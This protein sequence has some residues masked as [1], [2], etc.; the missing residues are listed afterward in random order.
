MIELIQG[1]L[2][3]SIAMLTLIVSVLVIFLGL[4]DDKKSKQEQLKFIL[5]SYAVIIS[6]I[7]YT[8]KFPN[9]MISVLVLFFVI[10]GLSYSINDKFDLEKELNI[11][12]LLLYSSFSWFFITSNYILIF[13]ILL[14]YIL[15]HILNINHNLSLI[16]IS[17]SLI[18][19]YLSIVKDYFGINSYKE[20]FYNLKNINLGVK[21]NKQ[22]KDVLDENFINENLDL[23]AFVLYVEDRYL[24][25]R[26]Q[27]HITF[28]DILNSKRD[29]VI[30][31]NKIKYESK[32]WFEKYIEKYIRGYSTIEQQLI[33]QYSI[34]EQAY[35]YKCRRKLFFDWIYTPL[36]S[37]A[38]CRRKS[39][40][41][42]KKKKI[43]KKELIWNLKM[44]FLYNYFIN[45]LKNP[46]NKNELINNMSQ[47]SRVEE[48]VY[49]KMFEIFSE[50]SKKEEMK[51]KIQDNLQKEYNF[52]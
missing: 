27:S 12:Q 4:N 34:S 37:K 14:I 1:N 31:K 33:R 52:Y 20:T 39:R 15:V 48:N 42:G 36:F 47:Q 28:M 50:S 3:T 32:S 38:I 17:I 29:P 9:F 6:I 25:D 7:L 5:V 41:Y 51:R 16:I 10:G 24:F 49:K 43:A 21:N 45:V 11:P 26:K 30:F 18:L 46:K 35:R 40:V 2:D 8:S 19:Q 22:A 13:N 23:V 44:M